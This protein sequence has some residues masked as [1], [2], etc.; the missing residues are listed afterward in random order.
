MIK[1]T[2]K[3]NLYNLT[4]YIKSKELSMSCIEYFYK[5]KFEK[6]DFIV[7]QLLR[8]ITSIGANIA[9]GYGR[10]YSNNYRLFLSIAR[11]S[12]FE[13]DYW[14]ELAIS[15][16]KYNNEVLT[17]FKEKNLEL[18]KMITTTMINLERRKQS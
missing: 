14:L 15:L 12:C 4:I 1:T 17:E 5:L 13:V 6:N 7:L 2:E 18:I 3:P 11:G 16:K 8:A 9:E 10:Y